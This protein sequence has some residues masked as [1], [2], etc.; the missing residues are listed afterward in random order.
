MLPLHQT[1]AYRAFSALTC[2]L[3]IT[4]MCAL[5]AAQEIVTLPGTP[6]ESVETL[7][8]SSP[9]NARETKA[10][11]D[12]ADQD[13]EQEDIFKSD[14]RALS[15]AFRHAAR[16][17]TPAVVTVYS[18]GQNSQQSNPQDNTPDDDETAPPDDETF[19]PAPPPQTE[20]EGYQL[21]GLGSGVIVDLM[22]TG[23]P[24]T[25]ATADSGTAKT[26]W[27]ITNNHVITGAKRVVVQF[28]DESELVAENVY[29][30]PDSDVAVLRLSSERDL[31]I[32]TMGDSDPIEIGD[33][34]LA[35]GSPFKLEATVCAGIISAKHRSISKIRRGRLFQT[36]AA[37]N[38]GNSGGPLVNLDGEVIAISTAIATRNGGYQGIGFAIPINQ[39]HWIARELAEFQRVRRAAIGVTLAD[40]NPK[41]AKKVGMPTYLGVLVA[42]VI[43]N[44]AAEV[45]GLQSMDVILEFAG[46]R[47]QRSRALQQAVEQQ[48]VGS[49]QDIKIWRHGKELSKQIVLAPSDDPTAVDTEPPTE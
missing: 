32:A 38:P 26:Y 1:T 31:A 47:V 6:A 17:A 29:G 14:A 35:I 12:A 43:K 21:T 22:P 9:T 13:T 41:L 27:V 10:D 36:D 7:G 49:T 19:G 46:Q 40:L 23:E 25:P 2:T 33:W 24:S 34:V 3:V 8:P 48:P 11:S 45:A 39:A 42:Q 37:I 16:E 28:P 20:D 5:A 30:D 15:E 18:Y 4:L 44:S